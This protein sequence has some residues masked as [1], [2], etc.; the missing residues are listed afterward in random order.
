MLQHLT[1]LPLFRFQEDQEVTQLE[2][3]QEE[4]ITELI[5]AICIKYGPSCIEAMICRVCRVQEHTLMPNETVYTR[6]YHPIP[7]DRDYYIVGFLA[8]IVNK[9]HMHHM[10]AS[11]C[12]ADIES[13]YK[14]PRDAGFPEQPNN[15]S[16]VGTAL[17]LPHAKCNFSL[18]AMPQKMMR[19]GQCAD[20]II[21]LCARQDPFE[22]LGVALRITEFMPMSAIGLQPEVHCNLIAVMQVGRMQD[23][24]KS[25]TSGCQVCANAPSL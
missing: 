24:N 4:T 15:A 18:E 19:Q 20:G 1:H 7:Q 5:S 25:R 9:I 21:L 17:V 22:G 23:A 13:L 16:N 3:Q 6:V 12:T 8:N 14:P 10:V 11:F 2:R